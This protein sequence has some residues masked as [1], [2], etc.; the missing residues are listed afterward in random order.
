MSAG[1]AGN[2]VFVNATGKDSADTL[3]ANRRRIRQQARKHVGIR[4]K[5][6]RLQSLDIRQVNVGEGPESA[7]SKYGSDTNKPEAQYTELVRRPLL[8]R[9][10]RKQ[11]LVPRSQIGIPRALAATDYASARVRYNFDL[12]WLSSLTTSH[13]GSMRMDE[14]LSAWLQHREKTFLDFIPAYYGRS[15][16]LQRVV[17]SILCK[18]FHLLNSSHKMRKLSLWTYGQ[19]LREVQAALSNRDLAKSTELLCAIRLLQIYEIL[20]AT[21]REERVSELSAT[22]QA[23]NPTSET[24]LEEMSG[25][26]DDTWPITGTHSIGSHTQGMQSLVRMRSPA[27]FKTDIDRSLLCSLLENFVRAP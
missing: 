18:A 21:V 2:F 14:S 22:P 17:D 10:P 25:T 5:T 26:W 13:V 8:D 12:S 1:G 11:V 27:S 9:D 6:S 4:W 16:L 24:D 23:P 20:E 19:A 3:Q 15:Q 7:T